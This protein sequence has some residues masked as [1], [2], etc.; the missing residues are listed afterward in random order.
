MCVESMCARVQVTATH[1][2]ITRVHGPIA[3]SKCTAIIAH[4]EADTWCAHRLAHG[5]A[6]TH[7][8]DSVHGLALACSVWDALL[9]VERTLGRSCQRYP[10]AMGSSLA[11]REGAAVVV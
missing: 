11:Q 8:C 5:H 10:S 2:D 6:H 1:A 7:L 9:R 3:A 4:V